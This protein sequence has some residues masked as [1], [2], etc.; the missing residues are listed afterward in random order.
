MSEKTSIGIILSGATTR[1]ASCQLLEEA[2]SGEIFEGML[3]LI[4]LQNKKPVLA[5]ISGIIP[6]NAFYTEGDPWSEARRKNLPIPENI[7]RQ[8]E[9][10]KLELLI[11]LGGYEVKYPPR[12]GDYVSRIDPKKHVKDIFGISPTDPKYVWYGSLIGYENCPIPL[13]VEKIPMHMAIF[14]TTGSGKSFDTG[15]LIEKLLNIPLN[16][17]TRLSF[18][19]LIIDAN[20]DYL[21]YIT[22]IQKNKELQK[23]GWIKRFIFP[24]NFIK[25]NIDNKDK[26][27][28]FQ[29]KIDL[30]ALSKRELAETIIMFY[31]GT[32]EGAELQLSGIVTLFDFMEEIRSYSSRH[33]L[34]VNNYQDL[35]HTLFDDQQIPNNIIAY[36]TKC[37]MQRSFEKFREIDV[38]HRLLSNKNHS[39]LTN[40]KFIDLITKEG[41]IAIIDFSEEGATGIDIAIKQLVMTYLATILFNQFAKF[42]ITKKERYLLFLI[43]EAQ[44]FVP[45]SSYP[46]GSSLA[47]NKLS[48]IATQGRKFGLSLCLISQRPSFVNRIVLSMCNTFFIHRLS[49]EDVNYVKSVTGG[50]PSTFSNKLTSLPQGELIVSGQMNK[51]PFPLLIKIKKSDR[52]VIHTAGSTNVVERLGALRKGEE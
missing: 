14:G 19:M 42:K 52:T 26:E 7:A 13:D 6:Y 12:P 5:R 38:Q 45:D 8:Y 51:V 30:D 15:V 3:V 23:V 2:E 16:E 28:I 18:P 32:T 4:H 24:E 34:F 35:I 11:E 9:I 29:I 27:H 31:K 25:G 49:P 40:E 36:Q 17:T 22:H 21:D 43:E 41:G 10:C 44:N 47:K 46:V 50:L 37:A 39:L 20:G 1:E 48:I 33:D